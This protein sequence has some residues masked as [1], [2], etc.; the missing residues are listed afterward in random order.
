VPVAH[1]PRNPDDGEQ[2]AVSCLKG[3]RHA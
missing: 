2:R 1:G 3:Q